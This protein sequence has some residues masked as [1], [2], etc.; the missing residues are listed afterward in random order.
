MNTFSVDFGISDN[1]LP[2]IIEHLIFYAVSIQLCQNEIEKNAFNPLFRGKVHFYR[3]QLVAFDKDVKN[4]KKQYRQIQSSSKTEGLSFFS[5]TK[6]FHQDPLA[7]QFVQDFSAFQKQYNQFLL[8]WS[9]LKK[10]GSSY[11]AFSE[12]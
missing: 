7:Q 5:L 2:H 10:Q 3:F 8:D 1:Y 4:L 11:W 12:N 9:K 6:V